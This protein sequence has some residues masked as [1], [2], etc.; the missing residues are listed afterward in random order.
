MLG[1]IMNKIIK[2]IRV[3]LWVVLSDTLSIGKNRNKKPKALIMGVLFF[4]IVMSF[5]A[6]VYCMMIG[7]GLKMYH[8]LE[9]LPALVL[10]ATSGVVFVTTIFKVK[11]TIFSFRDYD[12][13]MS[14]PLSNGVIAISR[15]AILYVLNILFVLIIMI[16]MI[17]AYGFL[18]TPGISFY[19]LAVITLFMVPL[20]PIIAASFIGTLIA[21][22]STKFKRSNVIN[23]VISILFFA[24]IIS[25]SFMINGSGQQLIDISKAL[26]ARINQIYPLAPY[27]A[28]GLVDQDLVSI[29]IFSGGSIGAFLLY[30]VLF[31]KVFKRMNT[32]MMTGS[33]KSNFKMKEL[34]TSSPI[35]ALY[36]KEL[37]RYFSSTLYVTNTGFGIVMLTIGVIA[38]IFVNIEKLT[39]SSGGIDAFVNYVPV[40]V[41]FC[42]LFTC[43]TMVSIS[44]EGKQFWIIK[45]LPVV[46]KTVYLAKIGMNLTI[47]SPAMID[48]L[49]IGLI[50]KMDVV[51]ILCMLLVA[52]ACAVFISLYG[53]V[54]NLLLPNFEW[55]AEVT[56]IKQ[57]AATMI[58]IFSGMGYAALLFVFIA[59]IPSAT[60]AYLA[61][62]LLTVVIDVILYQVIMTYGIRRYDTF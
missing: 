31:H 29:I 45:S 32:L 23:L 56:V 26:S 41:I 17:I 43:T 60:L 53:L 22:I 62:F 58:A 34:K 46:P 44:L 39:S 37:K 21:Y 35:K 6:F 15:L 55:T 25:S 61:Y 20:I 19:V 48:A 54:I 7:V 57:S 11:G 38:L 28:K 33:A 14:L 13:V 9:L 5:V 27:Y 59:V 24:A 16:P 2:L 4:S 51:R 50:L 30:A 12:M 18:A 1:L 52:A 8:S 3:Q 40:Y 10:A 49:F 36:F 47:I 42:I